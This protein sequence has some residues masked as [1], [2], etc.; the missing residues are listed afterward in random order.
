MQEAG[1]DATTE[2]A[3]TLAN[4]IE[5]MR[6]AVSAGLDIDEVGPRA[7]FF[8][9]IGMHFYIEIAKLRAAR[10]LWAEWINKL[11]KPKSQKSLMLRTH[12]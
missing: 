6:T 9:G 4:G 1:A 3:F 8:F 12:C 5:Y 10:K 11:F 7:S 2:L